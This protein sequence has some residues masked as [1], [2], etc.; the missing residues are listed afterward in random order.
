MT[1][2][3]TTSDRPLTLADFRARLGVTQVELASHLEINPSSVAKYEA[4]TSEGGTEPRRNVLRRLLRLSLASGVPLP[5]WLDKGKQKKLDELLQRHGIRLDAQIGQPLAAD[6]G[7]GGKAWA[8]LEEGTR[9]VAPWAGE[10]ALGKLP[11]QR[12][13]ATAVD[14]LAER[15]AELN[16]EVD[17][18]RRENARLQEKLASTEARGKPEKGDDR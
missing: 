4:S 14:A 9:A 2:K 15:I 13:E 8:A 12:R 5:V 7:A 10:A 3:T 17:E 1:K 6:P 16:R 11:P 18:L